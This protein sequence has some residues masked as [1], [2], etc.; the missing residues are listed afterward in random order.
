MQQPN[1]R[2]MRR[3]PRSVRQRRAPPISPEAE[4]VGDDVGLLARL[5]QDV[6]HRAMRGVERG[7]ERNRGHARHRGNDPKMRSIRIGG[8]RGLGLDGMALCAQPLRQG[9]A[10]PGLSDLLRADVCGRSRQPDYRQQ[11]PSS[12]HLGAELHIASFPSSMNSRRD[13]L[14]Q[15]NEAAGKNWEP[16]AARSRRHQNLPRACAKRFCER[17]PRLSDSCKRVIAA[18]KCPVDMDQRSV[19]SRPAILFLQKVQREVIEMTQHRDGTQHLFLPSS[20][21]PDLLQGQA[22]NPM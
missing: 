21:M 17:Q 20:A 19:G 4:N 10:S 14:T 13:S 7:S 16:A 8:C 18:L 6:G 2:T 3:Q 11:D 9:K 1:V 15:V 22:R 12:V 5:E